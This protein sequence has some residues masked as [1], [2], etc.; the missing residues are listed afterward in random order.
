MANLVVHP[1]Q[2]IEV[3]VTPEM[4][5]LAQETA[6]KGTMNR[7]SMLEG[8][9]NVEGLLG[10]LAVHKYLLIALETITISRFR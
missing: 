10:E 6:H 2:V 5:K 4:L 7:Q 1:S 8:S 3:I 9:R